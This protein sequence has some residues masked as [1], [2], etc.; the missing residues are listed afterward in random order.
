MRAFILKRDTLQFVLHSGLGLGV[1][2]LGARS[3]SGGTRNNPVCTSGA[4][5]GTR[6]AISARC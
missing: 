3:S 6:A 4:D 1:Y 5:G 2:G